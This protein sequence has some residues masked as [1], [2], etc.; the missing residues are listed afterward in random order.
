[1]PDI[2]TST[3]DILTDISSDTP[4]VITSQPKEDVL[5][6]LDKISQLDKENNNADS[7]SSCPDICRCD[8]SDMLKLICRF[9][10]PNFNVHISKFLPKINCV[11]IPNPFY[12]DQ[13]NCNCSCCVCFDTIQKA[14]KDDQDKASRPNLNTKSDFNSFTDY[15]DHSDHS[16]HITGTANSPIYV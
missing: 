12:E 5:G 11:S 3:S 13:F 4:S 2:A 1:M 14:K 9:D 10:L 6:N 16:D 8:F 15:S 7:V